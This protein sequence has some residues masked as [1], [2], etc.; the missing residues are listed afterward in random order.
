MAART[1][2]S[3]RTTAIGTPQSPQVTCWV[4]AGMRLAR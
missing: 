1:A 2:S 4:V 3:L